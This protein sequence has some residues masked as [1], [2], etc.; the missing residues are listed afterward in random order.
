MRMVG[1]LPGQPVTPLTAGQAVEAF[2]EQV[3]DTVVP[4]WRPTEGEWT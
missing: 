3:G 2:F 4:Q 1:Q